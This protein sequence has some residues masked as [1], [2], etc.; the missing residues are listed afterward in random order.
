VS[1]PSFKSFIKQ[2]STSFKIIFAVLSFGIGIYFS[3]IPLALLIFFGYFGIKF[4]IT[5]DNYKTFTPLH[6]KKNYYLFS[7]KQLKNFNSGTKYLED[8]LFDFQFCKWDKP[9][10]TNQFKAIFKQINTG[11]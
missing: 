1:T 6:S 4:F 10:Q 9:E 11:L 5:Q 8:F 2:E 7:K 3:F